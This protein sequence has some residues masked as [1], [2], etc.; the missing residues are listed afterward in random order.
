[1]LFVVLVALGIL[2]LTDE[3]TR[4]HLGGL[5]KPKNQKSIIEKEKKDGP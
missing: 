2:L 4:K 5:F 1:M 3:N